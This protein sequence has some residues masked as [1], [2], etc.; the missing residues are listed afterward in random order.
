MTSVDNI[1]CEMQL[2]L[3]NSRTN[4]KG[5]KKTKLKLIDSYL[6]VIKNLE[7][8]STQTNITSHSN[9]TNP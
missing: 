6:I 3:P 1:G 9:L 5:K 2:A 4:F 7:N 8:I